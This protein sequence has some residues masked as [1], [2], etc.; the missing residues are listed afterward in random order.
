[1]EKTSAAS[2]H[3]AGCRVMMHVPMPLYTDIITLGLPASRCLCLHLCRARKLTPGGG[4]IGR[5]AIILS[6]LPVKLSP[7]YAGCETQTHT[8]CDR[9]SLGEEQGNHPAAPLARLIKASH[10]CLIPHLEQVAA[11]PGDPFLPRPSSLT[12]RD[13]TAKQWQLQGR[14]QKPFLCLLSVLI[15]THVHSQSWHHF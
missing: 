5:L 11:S 4:K 13:C 9:H 8:R 2:K 15:E 10:L 14:A 7:S 6:S 3:K 1:M 12:P